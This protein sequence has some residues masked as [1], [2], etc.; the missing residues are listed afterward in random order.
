MRNDEP[1][2]WQTLDSALTSYLNT[3]T[4]I[5]NRWLLIQTLATSEMRRRVLATLEVQPGWR[6]LDVGTGFGS[7]PMEL[8]AMVPVDAVGI[9]LDESTLAVAETVRVDVA[10]R[11]GF[12]AGSHVTFLAGDAYALDEPDA[13]V[14]LATARFLFQHLRDHATAAAELARVVRP[15][16]LAC[17]IDVDDGLSLT[18]PE[19]S[20]AYL[21][22]TRALTAMQ[23]CQGGGRQVARTLPA[24]LDQVGFDVVAVL[25]LPQAA[26][27]SSKPGDMNRTLLVDRFLAARGE[28][29]E[30]FISA[31]EF[32]E[33]LRRFAAEI[34]TG[35]C[36]VEAH[37]AVIGR[38]R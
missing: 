16:G 20:E 12:L 35:E 34:T 37:L 2:G 17:L 23:E 3:R 38:R 25:V 19:P 1:A 24:R 27:R 8:A 29:V 7:V 31:D 36:A 30:G 6:T 32:D 9:D 33:C 26:Y 15:G 22:L 4:D 5:P 21:R 10:G 11:D 13:S 14:D 18:H 28:L